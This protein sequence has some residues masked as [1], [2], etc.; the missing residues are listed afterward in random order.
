MT[1]TPHPRRTRP[2]GDL[3]HRRLPDGAIYAGRPGRY[4]NPHSVNK[5][6]TQPACGGA[7][8]DLSEALRL[9]EQ[10][11]DTHPEVARQAV[12]EPPGTL[13]ACWCKPDAPCHVDLLLTRADQI[14][15]QP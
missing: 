15:E 3:F 6:C 1:T 9:Y 13:F 4:G 5:P 2:E 11:L 7:V 8:H 10:H 12:G 14:A